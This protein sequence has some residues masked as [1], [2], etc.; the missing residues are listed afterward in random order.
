LVLPL[1]GLVIGAIALIGLPIA[2]V[3]T[4][5]NDSEMESIGELASNG[6]YTIGWLSEG[7]FY[8][9]IKALPAALVVI[10]LFNFAGNLSSKVVG[11]EL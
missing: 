3:A 1:I 10:L 4:A 2:M 9:A 8:G 6:L 5:P 7:I 11:E